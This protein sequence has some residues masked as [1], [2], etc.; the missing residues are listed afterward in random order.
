MYA[1]SQETVG[2]MSFPLESIIVAHLKKVGLIKKNIYILSDPLCR[3]SH[4]VACTCQLAQ[5]AVVPRCAFGACVPGRFAVNE[6]D[7]KHMHNTT[8]VKSVTGLLRPFVRILLWRCSFLVRNLFK[9]TLLI[10]LIPLVHS[11]EVGR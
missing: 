4:P 3:S 1:F 11:T 7:N 5:L 6:E 10:H 8:Y 9:V 2:I